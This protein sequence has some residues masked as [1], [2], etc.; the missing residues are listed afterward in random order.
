MRGMDAEPKATGK[1]S[2]R[3]VEQIPNHVSI[4]KPIQIIKVIII[5]KLT[6]NFASLFKSLLLGMYLHGPHTFV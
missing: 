6:K 3:F 5:S 1:Y 4:I 2:R